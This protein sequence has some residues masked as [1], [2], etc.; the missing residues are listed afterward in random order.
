MDILKIITDNITLP[1]GFEV[2]NTVVKAIEKE[3]KMEQ[4]KNYVLKDAYEE[5]MLVVQQLE[6]QVK[7]LKN[8]NLDTELY[9]NKVESIQNEF[10]EFKLS[11]KKDLDTLK[12][13]SV[14]ELE[15]YKL[16]IT[17]EKTLSTKKSLLNKTL[18]KDGA[19]P[20]I[21][22]LIAKTFDVESLEIENDV[23]KDWDNISKQVKTD[24][25]DYF[26]TV[27]TTG[28]EPAILPTQG[29]NTSNPYTSQLE[30][31]RVNKDNVESVRIKM[32]AYEEGIS[33]R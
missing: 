13:S 27:V 20:K 23:I 24:Y 8:S 4:S 18:L 11:S 6:N 3:L 32:Q 31:A 25:S 17:N 9:K 15:D 7:K 19:L 29:D 10:E 28:H 22:D 12:L 2:S 16:S 26:G 33:F 21:V 5:K 14:K 1:D 30:K